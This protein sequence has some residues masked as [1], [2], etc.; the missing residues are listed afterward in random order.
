VHRRFAHVLSTPGA[1]AALLSGGAKAL[2]ARMG[3]KRFLLSALLFLAALLAVLS[4]AF[5]NATAAE[6]ALASYEGADYNRSAE[7]FETMPGAAARYNAANAWY[8]AGEYERALQLYRAVEA[9]GA[10]A[11][12]RVWFNRGNT[13]V[14]LKEFAKARDAYARSLALYYD[15]AALENMMHILYAE[16]QDHMLTG[17][18]EGKK[19]VQDQEEEGSQEQSGRQKEGGGSNQQSAAER[20]RGAGSQGKKVEREAQLEF[21]NKGSSTLSS[22]QY[23]LINQRS[24][25]ETKPW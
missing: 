4:G 11:A 2:R 18:Q 8:R 13:L 21:S 17:R 3:G 25:H 1:I 16:E 15:E 12:A 19:R 14:R 10:E 7:L 24:V 20:N 22:K 9:P 6:R 5:W 23:E